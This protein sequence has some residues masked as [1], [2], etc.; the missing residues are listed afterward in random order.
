MSDAPDAWAA[1]LAL[2]PE[3]AAEFAR[4]ATDMGLKPVEILR[5]MV[6]R[7]L[8]MDRSTRAL[9]LRGIA[10][11]TS[12]QEAADVAADEAVRGLPLDV[13]PTGFMWPDDVPFPWSAEECRAAVIGY[14]VKWKG[15]FDDFLNRLR[16]LWELSDGYASLRQP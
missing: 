4:L 7:V 15:E 9:G 16:G 1:A 14:E 12:G 10:Y 5:L 8:G 3:Q 13:R 6:A 11:W 2:P